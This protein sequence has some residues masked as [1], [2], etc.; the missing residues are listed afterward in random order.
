MIPIAYTMEFSIIEVGVK[1]SDWHIQFRVVRNDLIGRLSL[2]NE[3][4]NDHVFLMQFL[5]CHVY[6][7]SGWRQTFPCT[8][9]LQRQHR[10]GTCEQWNNDG[11]L[12]DIHYRHKEPYQERLHCSLTKSGQVW[13]QVGQEVHL[14]LQSMIFLHTFVFL[15]WYLWMQKLWALRKDPLWYQ[16]LTRWS[17][18]SL[19]IVV[20]SLHKKRAISLK[21]LPLFRERSMYLRSSRERCF[22]LPGIYLLM[23]ISFYCCQK[24]SMSIARIYERLNS[25][26]AGVNSTA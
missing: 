10:N 9:G 23:E 11:W 21:E 14:M 2:I 8:C 4:S 7:S 3:R 18:T 20:G 6:T 12:S 15:Q 13:L 5:F 1:G 25:T 17:F 26:H 19:E 22:W 16:S 24:V